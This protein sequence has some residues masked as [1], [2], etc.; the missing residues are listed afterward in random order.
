MDLTNAY[1]KTAASGLP[2]GLYLCCE[3]ACPEMV[4]STINPFFISLPMTSISGGND[5]DGGTDWIYDVTIY[6]KSLTGIPQSGED[7]AGECE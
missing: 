5:A 1:G 4:V 3:T 6:P 2:L 7:A